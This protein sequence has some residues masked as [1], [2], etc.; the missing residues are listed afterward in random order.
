MKFKDMDQNAMRAF[1]ETVKSITLNE[2]TLEKETSISSKTGKYYFT[3][4]SGAY[5]GVDHLIL[6]P[7]DA[8]EKVNTLTIDAEGYEILTVKF[9]QDGKLLFD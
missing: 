3:L 6:S 1:K 7:E 4:I 9:D 8:K 2:K 5:S